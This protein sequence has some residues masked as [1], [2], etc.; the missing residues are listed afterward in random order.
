MGVYR[1]LFHRVPIP[2]KSIKKT[3]LAEELRARTEECK[4]ELAKEAEKL[5]AREKED[6][7]KRHQEHL[8][9]LTRRSIDLCRKEVKRGKLQA[10]MTFGI[11][12]SMAEELAER[13]REEGFEVIF[14]TT[15][16]DYIGTL[17]RVMW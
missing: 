14:P 8:K 3:T 2:D 10:D 15:K 7:K 11:S 1:R 6:N 13:L 9:N 5:A 16:L 17:I 12:K 4:I